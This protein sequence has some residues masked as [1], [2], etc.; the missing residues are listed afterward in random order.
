MMKSEIHFVHILLLLILSPL[1]CVNS[2]NFVLIHGGSHGAW[3]WYK[4][5]TMLK[6]TGHNVTTIELAASGIN[7]IQVQDIHSISKYYKPLMVFM[8]SLPPNEKV[9]LVGHSLGG[10]STSVAMEK[11]P[12]KISVAVFVTAYVLSQNLTYPALLQEVQARRNGSLM[13]TNFF[14]FDGPN[15]PATARLIG[16]KF[17]ASKM[18][19]L[20]PPK[21]LTL[22]LSLVRPVPIYKDVEL[23]LKETKVT[24]HRNGRVPKVS[25]PSCII[26]EDLQMWMIKR[27]GPFVK[28]KV[29]KDSDYMIMFFSIQNENMNTYLSTIESLSI[30]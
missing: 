9:I 19:Q 11:F 20:S 27:S 17:M 16:P 14:F 28:L 10:V 13:D 4:V 22:A 1:I 29:I 24:N 26:Y 2:A 7:Q 21:D 12:Q 25:K 8:E 18:Y 3:C 15:K 30:S 6:S 5:A 23:L